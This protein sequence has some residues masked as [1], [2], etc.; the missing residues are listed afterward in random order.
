MKTPDNYSVLIKKGILTTEIAADVIYS[1]NKRAK[2]WRDKNPEKYMKVRRMRMEGRSMTEIPYN[3]AKSFDYYRDK[4]FLIL[5]LFQPR[6]IHIID[7]VEYLYY[8]V[9]RS[10]FHL[11]VYVFRSYGRRLPA[12]L[13]KEEGKS[14]TTPG[15]NPARLLSLQFCRSVIELVKNNQFI[16]I[17]GGI[18]SIPARLGGKQEKE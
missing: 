5:T 6:K 11:P 3:S 12:G 2:N 7:G 15:E 17:D 13:A 18:I 9:H 1:L 8:S 16:L 10:V 14:Y 4:D